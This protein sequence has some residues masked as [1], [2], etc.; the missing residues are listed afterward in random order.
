MIDPQWL[1]E[2]AD[3]LRSMKSHPAA[4]PPVQVDGGVAVVDVSGVL[5]HRASFVD[6]L[7]GGVSSEAVAET[8]RELAS[9]EQV[10]A[11][12]LRIDSPGGHAQGMADVSRMITGAAAVK[13]V[14]AFADGLMA[15]AA[16]YLAS[17]ASHIAAAADD[18]KVGSIGTRAVLFDT[19]EAAKQ[20]GVRP[21]VVDTGPHKSV[22]MPG[23]EVTEAQVDRVREMVAKIQKGFTSAVADGRQLSSDSLLEVLS[24]K[25]YFADEAQALGLIDSVESFSDTLARARALAKENR[26]SS[27]ATFA[28]LKA[29]LPGASSEFLCEALEKN[30]T[31]DA[32]QSSWMERQSVEA[33]KVAEQ[34]EQANATIA[35]LRQKIEKLEQAATPGV[36]PS[37]LQEPP[38]P[39]VTDCRSEWDQQIAKEIANGASRQQAV[40]RVNKKFP[41][42]RRQLV[43]AVNA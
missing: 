20:A 24:G 15:S 19:S 36:D 26:M 4:A 30:W 27:P 14:V 34:L 16:Y 28:D 35:E 43:A 23:V 25:I 12:V 42:L 8:V 13:P 39:V 9:D 40:A 37:Q 31:L 33:D 21:I 2:N 18:S 6:A 11:I 10:D 1:A 17:G 38:A 7:F 41:E 32:A 5:L 29:C 22:G 3:Q